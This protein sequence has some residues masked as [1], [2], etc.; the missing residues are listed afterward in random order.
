VRMGQELWERSDHHSFHQI[1]VPVLFFFEGLPITRNADYHTWRDTVDQLD[2]D[3]MART[4]RLVFNT[5]WLLA[6]DPERPPA[7]R[8]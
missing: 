5:A 7:P 3:K 6:S 2:F 8:E 4:T 1:G